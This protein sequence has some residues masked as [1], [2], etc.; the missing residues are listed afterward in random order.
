MNADIINSILFV[1][2]C[3]LLLQES[4]SDDCAYRDKPQDDSGVSIVY[5]I[6]DFTNR[7]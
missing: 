3:L 6:L 5:F 4:G 7:E 1:F 2:Y